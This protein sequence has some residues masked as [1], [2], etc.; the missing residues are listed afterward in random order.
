MGKKGKKQKGNAKKIVAKSKKE[1]SRLS[2]FY[3]VLVLIVS[4][5]HGTLFFSLADRTIDLINH[6]SLL[7]LSYL[8]FFFSLFFRIF[9]THLL[10]AVKYTEKWTF[11]PM[12]FLLV[13]FTA[14]F[15]YILFSKEEIVYDP[16]KW[17]FPLI[18]V[19]WLFGALGYLTTYIRTRKSYQG[20][21]RT[22]EL[23]LQIINILCI[24]I[25]GA[26]HL[27]CYFEFAPIIFNII[28]IN[29]T[30]FVVFIINIYFSLS[31]SKEELKNV[32]HI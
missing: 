13:F 28:H 20:K 3:E 25:I 22:L 16:H 26:L 7:N 21:N 9:Q 2:F 14:L 18:F 5:L 29:L 23:R 12:D 32:L 24:S 8:L 11:K 31:F 4:L 10:A 17:Y 15:E 27:L 19:F 1:Q 30:S 6:F